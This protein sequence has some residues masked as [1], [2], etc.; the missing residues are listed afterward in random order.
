LISNEVARLLSKLNKPSYPCI[1]CFGTKKFH[2]E[3]DKGRTSYTCNY[4]TM[5]GNN[6]YKYVNEINYE[7][8][9]DIYTKGCECQWHWNFNGELVDKQKIK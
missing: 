6:P 2:M 8:I 7:T 1:G 4:C 9:F 3:D 5:R